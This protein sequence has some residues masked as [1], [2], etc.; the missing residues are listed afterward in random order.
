MIR[1]ERKRFFSL[2]SSLRI[3]GM[4]TYILWRGKDVSKNSMSCI[5]FLEGNFLASDILHEA[6]PPKRSN[7]D[8]DTNDITRQFHSH[9]I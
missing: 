6:S 8:V 3:K 7:D 9:I 2:M 5:F 1:P 4:Y